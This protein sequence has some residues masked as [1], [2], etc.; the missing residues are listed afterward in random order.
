MFGFRITILGEKTAHAFA[1]PQ[2]STLPAL[3]IPSA[4]TGYFLLVLSLMHVNRSPF[5]FRITERS[6]FSKYFLLF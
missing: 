6:M 1:F 5:K 3:Y 2:I 4:K